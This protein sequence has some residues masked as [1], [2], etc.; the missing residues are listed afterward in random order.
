MNDAR[1]EHAQQ[2]HLQLHRHLGDLVEEDRA[3]VGAL[4]EAL[5][6]A[7]RAR[8]AAALV[9]E[10]LALDELRRDGAAIQRQER[11][12]APPAQL[13]DGVRGELLAGAALA[14]QQRGGRSGR[15]AAQLI[16]EHLHALR[17]AENLAEAAEL[18]QRIAQLAD[19]VLQGRGLLR[20]AKH[21]LHALE[22]RGLDEVVAR[23]RAQRSHRAVD[24]RVTGDDDD[25]GGV[26]LFQ[27]AHELDA[28]AIGQAQIGQQH[29]RPLPA[30]LD[31]RLAQRMRARDREAF[32]ACD[33]LQPVH[34]IRV[35]IDNQ[36]MCH[37]IPRYW[38]ARPVVRW[39][40]CNPKCPTPC[41][42][43]PSPTGTN[44]AATERSRQRRRSSMNLLI[45]ILAIGAVVAGHALDE[46]RHRQAA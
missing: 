32:H 27:L 40:H 24:G 22:I 42:C 45:G 10:Q 7:I 8:E 6:L 18:A 4:E 19:L 26:R 29:V 41:N 9:A 28:F 2:F 5:V 35:V 38:G 31:A 15:D 23:A 43:L 37:C 17:A 30:E 11:R 33:F 44:R 21:R 20:M 16:V 34:D 46:K 39:C 25:F 1:L 3:A 36:R 14:D 13:V 12:F